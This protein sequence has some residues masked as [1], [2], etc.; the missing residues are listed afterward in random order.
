MREEGQ[1]TVLWL[2]RHGETEW[3]KTGQHTGKTDLPLTEWGRV[4][5]ASLKPVLARVR[6][7]AVLVSP[8][9]RAIQTCELAGLKPTRIEDDLQEWDYGDY[10]G[11]TKAQILEHNPSWLLWRDG[12]PNGESPAQVIARA[13]RVIAKARELGGTVALCTHGHMLRSMAVRALGLP[14]TFGDQLE[15]G[16]ASISRIVFEPESGASLE[17][18]NERQHVPG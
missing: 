6:F 7:D 2:I 12:C 4:E 10:D 14:F 15:L 16:T 1:P 5:G 18:W 3:S 8:R 9:K 17:T 11:K 13:D